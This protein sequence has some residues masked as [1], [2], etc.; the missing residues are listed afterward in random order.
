MTEA[1]DHDNSLLLESIV[2]QYDVGQINKVKP[3]SHGIENL[4][5]FL[6]CQK[7]GRVRHY[8]LTLVEQ[9]SFAGSAYL[10][11]MAHLADEGLPVPAPIKNNQGHTGTIQGGQMCLLQPKLSGQHTVNPTNSQIQAVGRFLGH[12]HTVG[13]EDLDIPDY[14]RDL[15]WL[16]AQADRLHTGP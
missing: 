7:D 9:P 1:R 10:P 12:L 11:M 2:S 8:V 5:Y 13:S 16:R 14:P 15:T 3:A 4:N 6:D